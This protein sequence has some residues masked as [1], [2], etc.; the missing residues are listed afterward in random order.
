MQ[1]KYLSIEGHDLVK[2]L[3]SAIGFTEIHI[4][5][6]RQTGAGSGLKFVGKSGP[7]LD[8][9]NSGTV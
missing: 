4:S 6:P 5:Q 7:T 9:N 1:K 8:L 3:N 2:Q